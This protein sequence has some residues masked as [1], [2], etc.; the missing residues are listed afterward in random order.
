VYVQKVGRAE[1]G[2]ERSNVKENYATL[3]TWAKYM[4]PKYG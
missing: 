1:K 3:L 2:K 4:E